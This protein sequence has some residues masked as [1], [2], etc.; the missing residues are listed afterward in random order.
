ME[1]PLQDREM[2]AARLA[3]SLVWRTMP[4]VIYRGAVYG[5]F[6][7]LTLLWMA[8]CVALGA[9]MGQLHP[10][11]ALLSVALGAGIW[12]ACAEWLKRYLTYLV[13][14]AHVAAITGFVRGGYT[15]GGL[16]QIGWGRRQIQN[17]FAD[18]SI[19]FTLQALV[20]K[21]LQTITSRLTATDDDTA[22]DD[23]SRDG[24]QE[25][26]A[27][28]T[29]PGALRRLMAELA[30]R[31]LRY[32]GE[33][34]LS[35]ALLQERQT[36]WESAR[37]GLLLFAQSY[38]SVIWSTVKLWVM[39]KLFFGLMLMLLALPALSILAL[40]PGQPLAQLAVIAST[41]LA[42][43]LAERVLYEPFALCYTLVTFH[44]AIDGREPDAGWDRR[45]DRL[46]SAFRILKSRAG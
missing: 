46:S 3:A 35:Y 34:I 18:V 6:F 27:E 15:P 23:A 30:E 32:T 19:L 16:A 1:A 33:T 39:S 20:A 43:G 45:L 24:E 41:F 7:A 12:A 13:R 25:E 28:A 5:G 4:F 42:A 2:G 17:R 26:G 8:C 14:G 22:T 40:V 11:L 21:I 10:V 37:R 29:G 36:I 38:R 9:L 44:R 31:S